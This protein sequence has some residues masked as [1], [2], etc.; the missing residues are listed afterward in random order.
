MWICEKW[1]SQLRLYGQ[2]TCKTISIPKI[3]A[4]CFVIISKGSHANTL[5]TACFEPRPEKLVPPVIQSCYTSGENTDT[6]MST[7]ASCTAN[8]AH[9]C[10]LC[11]FV[12][13]A[14]NSYITGKHLNV[15]YFH[16][17]LRYNHM[18]RIN[19]RWNS[20]KKPYCRNQKQ[21]NL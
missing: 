14:P 20:E 4:L 3:C 5:P 7:P 2:K 19:H 18:C 21:L 10:Y 15:I 9:C 17:N 8:W 6:P 16:L 1:I 13:A 12:T 11:F